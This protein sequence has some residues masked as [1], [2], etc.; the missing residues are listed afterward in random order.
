[1]EGS[2]AH[3]ALTA[4]RS[5]TTPRGH[6]EGQPDFGLI[7]PATGT[8]D[9]AA[10]SARAAEDPD[11]TLALLSHM[12]AAS[13]HKMALLAT[14]IAGR[15]ALAL[16][17]SGPSSAAGVGRIATASADRYEGDL[18]LDASLEA[19]VEASANGRPPGLD[20]LRVQHWQQPETAIS[21]AIDRSGSMVGPRLA[22]AAV[23]AAACALRAPQQWSV[24]AFG[25]RVVSLKSARS[26]RSA[27]AVVAD[28]LR[29]RGYGTTD[30]AAALE[31]SAEQLHRCTA[32]RKIA[33]L[34]SD[35]RATAGSDP[36]AAA[37]Q[38]DE[39]C[40][41]GPADD[42]DDAAAFASA[43]RARVAPIAGVRSIPG[44]IAAIIGP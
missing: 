36:V 40:V 43:A 33:L 26:Q 39:L 6:Y 2:R 8:I 18:D 28:V 17:R 22:V 37:Q 21:I 11:A 35:C 19:L 27:D 3:E 31:A 15:L 32:Q 41:L 9:S 5:R 14:R 16:A 7:S 23:A 34:L 13:D 38:L 30:L 12:A 42:F 24:L 44:A 1:M 25:D 10:V 4:E 29:L 20:E